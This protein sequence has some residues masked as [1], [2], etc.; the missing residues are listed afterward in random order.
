[1]ANEE[2]Q[3]ERE[4]ASLSELAKRGQIS[5]ET[6]PEMADYLQGIII[7]QGKDIR[8]SPP[9]VSFELEQFVDTNYLRATGKIDAIILERY[10]VKDGVGIHFSLSEGTERA[11]LVAKLVIQPCAMGS[12]NG[13]FRSTLEY[14][15]Q[16]P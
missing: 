9:N 5:Y 6:S 4:Y 12:G 8:F 14:R 13:E 10:Y 11:K 15:H 1:M 3:P 7:R 2:S 16:K